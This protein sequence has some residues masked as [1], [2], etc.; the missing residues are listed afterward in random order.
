MTLRSVQVR[1]AHRTP[2]PLPHLRVLLLVA[3]EPRE[4]AQPP[5]VRVLV[6]VAVEIDTE[7]ELALHAVDL[8]ELDSRHL[9]PGLVRVRVAAE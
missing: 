8:C 7:Q 3:H 4:H 1:S 6:D 5:V 9:G 2:R